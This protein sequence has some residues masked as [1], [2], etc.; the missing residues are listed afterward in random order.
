MRQPLLLAQLFFYRSLNFKNTSNKSLNWL[1]V[2]RHVRQK[3]GIN[4]RFNA[5]IKLKKDSK[6]T[7]AEVVEVRSY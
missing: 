1:K 5:F 2:N 4:T 7:Y 6:V 3:A